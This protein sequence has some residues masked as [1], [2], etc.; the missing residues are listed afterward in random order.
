[1]S[2]NESGVG[3]IM[4]TDSVLKS[5]VSI[6][7]VTAISTLLLVVVGIF[8]LGILRSQKRQTQLDLVEQYRKSWGA[9]S[10][11]LGAIIFIGRGSDEYYQLIDQSELEVLSRRVANSRPDKPDVWILKSSR[12]VFVLL[13]DICVKVLQG[14]MEVSFIYPIIGHDLLRHSRPLRTLLD[15]ENSRSWIDDHHETIKNHLIVRS[16]VQDWLIYHD[17]V[18]R[19]CLILLDLLWAEAA[20]LEDLPPADL[21]SAANAK[22]KT[23]SENRRRVSAECR[24]LNRQLV[25]PLA[26]K[27]SRFLKHSEYLS[28]ANCIGV[29]RKR[30]DKLDK[31]WTRRLLGK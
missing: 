29:S 6:D 8:Q 15:K 28:W 5:F 18:R 24:R 9:R 1:M 10:K 17:G 30:L 31:E 26:F 13:S 25:S 12:E 4:M 23:G 2:S 27:L 20:R 16:E 11:D 19:R 7:V 21:R 3:E 22:E 14:Q